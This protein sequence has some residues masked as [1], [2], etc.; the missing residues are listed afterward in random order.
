MT[1]AWQ[2]HCESRH[3]TLIIPQQLN[4]SP[5]NVSTHQTSASDG[6]PAIRVAG[7]ILSCP[8]GGRIIPTWS[9]TRV[10]YKLFLVMEA[11]M[12]EAHVSGID[13]LAARAVLCSSGPA[14]SAGTFFLPLS[15][16]V[17][18]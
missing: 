15:C 12:A 6:R 4:L 2:V 11:M 17:E 9:S 16:D 1:C 3:A 14:F 10:D 7:G 5:D 8:Y 18:C 13:F